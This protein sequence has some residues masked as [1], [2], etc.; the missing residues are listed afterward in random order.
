MGSFQQIFMGASCLA[1]AFFF[2]SYLHN[3]PA[4]DNTLVQTQVAPSDPLDSIFSFGKKPGSDAGS[5]TTSKATAPPGNVS[6]FAASP[7]ASPVASAIDPSELAPQSPLMTMSFADPQA[8]ESIPKPIV[9]AANRKP[10]VPDFSELASRF[11]NTPLELSGA[12]TPG[13]RSGAVHASERVP[14]SGQFSA[15]EMVVRQPESTKPLQDFRSQVDRIE[16]SIRGEFSAVET[17]P[18]RWRV[19]RT[20][21]IDQFRN[22][23]Q[24]P[25]P[26]LGRSNRP[27]SQETIEDVLSRR[28][29]D[30]LKDESDRE[31]WATDPPTDSWTSKQRSRVTQQAAM[32]NQNIL[33][34]EDPGNRFQSVLDQPE[35]VDPPEPDLETAYY[36]PSQQRQD[37]AP[38][39]LNRLNR[40]MRSIQS[41]DASN[42]GRRSNI[43][44]QPTSVGKTYTIQRGDTLQSISS[45]FYGSADYYLEIYKANREA[46]DRITSSPA[47]V[48]IEIPTLNN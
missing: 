16:D 15:P 32:R 21:A 17:Q 22:S 8:Q 7:I 39:P 34:I 47:G 38:Q 9:A 25:Q 2:G 23:N 29:A 33:D 14:L 45:R 30:Y 41:N 36:T 28:S 26:D 12:E 11:R 6:T 13:D 1:A 19:N 4:T 27:V 44:T 5:A 42:W 46:L 20:E 31:T 43:Q 35:Q 40:N 24:V 18:T 37:S 10:V 3:R 48:E